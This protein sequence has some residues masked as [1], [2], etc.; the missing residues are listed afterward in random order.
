MVLFFSKTWAA[1]IARPSILN[2]ASVA[3]VLAGMAAAQSIPAQ[4]VV[5]S[6][7]GTS[8]AG[9][10]VQPDVQ[11]DVQPNDAS[12]D[13]A[14]DPA[15]LLPDLPPLPREKAT[16]IGGTLERLDRV[17]DQLTVRVFGG[18][19]LRI[20]FDPRT[21][22]YADGSESS[23]SALR[24]GDRIYVDTILDGSTIFARNIRLKSTGGA[25]ESQGII[26]DYRSGKNEISLHDTL[27]QQPFKIHLTPRTIVTQDNH[28][29]SLSEL[30][31]GALVAVKFGAEAG[32]DS[33]Q[34]ITVLAVPGASFTFAGTV[35][36]VN[37]RLGILVL[38]SSTD[39]KTYEISFDPSMNTDANNLHPGA[40]VSVL[41]RFDGNRY[42]ANSL[43]INSQSQR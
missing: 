39:H 28:V 14:L 4:S 24:Q 19:K 23:L 16:L 38:E 15:S 18:G 25:G 30:T 5:S 20:T 32:S 10:N 1:R 12:A 11:P 27:S 6:P 42:V 34:E 22:V 29:A 3:L 31:P 8:G 9:A 2:L 21:H 37:L 35:T 26:V 40:A 43:A 7:S 17:R 33:A 36:A 13:A 41:T